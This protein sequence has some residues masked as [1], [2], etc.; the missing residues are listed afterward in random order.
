M[1]MTLVA[2]VA[3]SFVTVSSVALAQELQQ[4][5]NESAPAARGM[6]KGA[7]GQ[8]RPRAEEGATRPPQAQAQMG[9]QSPQEPGKEGAA[10]KPAANGERTGS[11]EKA[12]SKDQSGQREMNSGREQD[13]T[14]SQHGQA[15]KAGQVERNARGDE[16]TNPAGAALANPANGAATNQNN[17]AS[18]E[19]G[20]GDQSRPNEAATGAHTSAT[21]SN[22]NPAAPRNAARKVNPQEV[23]ASGNAHL[24]QENAARIA[25]ALNATATPRD[26]NVSV[27]VGGLLPG[28]V[29]LAPLPPSVVE[30]V[31]EYQGYDYVVANDDI[32][33]VQP[34]TRKVVEVINE[35]EGPHAMNESTSQAMSGTRV[36]PCGP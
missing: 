1:R 27:D 24:S 15:D 36:N 6:E 13:K 4:K 14:M 5:Q 20:Q 11:Q 28:D 33:I 16:R 26:I 29:D 18:E 2:A 22:A 10:A 31:P 30:F 8:A 12:T 35:G 7:P 32:V 9:S 19:R 3:A 21:A 34:S 23:H 17:Q 25:T